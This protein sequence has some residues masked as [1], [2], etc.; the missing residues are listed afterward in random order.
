M[1]D[2]HFWGFIGRL[3]ALCHP[4]NKKIIYQIFLSTQLFFLFQKLYYLQPTHNENVRYIY[5]KLY[6]D[7]NLMG[8]IH[9]FSNR[10]EILVKSS[11]TSHPMESTFVIKNS[12]QALKLKNMT[13]SFFF[14]NNFSMYIFIEIII[15][16]V[17]FL[18]STSPSSDS[19][20]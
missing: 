20:S 18:S 15:Y 10:C 13:I 5:F 8:T 2:A 4:I 11:L 17:Y 7:C 9:N 12:L 14:P 1:Y 6:L 3:Y 19:T 16:N